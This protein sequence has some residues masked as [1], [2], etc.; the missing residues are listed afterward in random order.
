L[1]R[2]ELIVTVRFHA[3]DVR[4]ALD[5]MRRRGFDDLWLVRS[6]T[7]IYFTTPEQ[8]RKFH[9]LR[10]G[11]LHG[12]LLSPKPQPYVEAIPKHNCVLRKLASLPEGRVESLWFDVQYNDLNEF[13]MFLLE[14]SYMGRNEYV[15]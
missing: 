7:S 11:K 9:P 8:G 1:V 13:R 4:A 15:P 3:V 10:I 5:R 12:R 6:R 14:S 2:N